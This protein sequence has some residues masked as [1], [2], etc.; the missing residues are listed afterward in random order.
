MSKKSNKDNYNEKNKI[1][2]LLSSVV[3]IQNVSDNPVVLASYAFDSSSVPSALPGYVVLPRTN[4]KV[5]AILEIANGKKKP[6]ATMY[7]F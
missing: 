1:F 6:F 4:M 5:K 7:L 3:G 2:E